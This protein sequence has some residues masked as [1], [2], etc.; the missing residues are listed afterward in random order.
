MRVRSGEK[1]QAECAT[2]G[3]DRFRIEE[4]GGEHL[5]PG[6]YDAI[7]VDC[8]EICGTMNGGVFR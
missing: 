4:R 7:C 8:G 1:T 3:G 2:C 6:G 5:G